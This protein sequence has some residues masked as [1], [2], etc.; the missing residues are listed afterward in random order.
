MSIIAF[1]EG[2][3]RHELSGFLRSTALLFS[4]SL[5]SLWSFC[6]F[7][8]Y[9]FLF[10]FSLLWSFPPLENFFFC[11]KTNLLVW[12]SNIALF[13][14]VLLKTERM[15]LS[16]SF[17]STVT[18]HKLSLRSWQQIAQFHVLLLDSSRFR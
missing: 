4:Y 11:T 15:N 1:V 10:Y 5:F 13:K 16:G 9:Y 6:G 2:L 12:T 3:Q 7:F 17:N 14:H 18:L 8:Y